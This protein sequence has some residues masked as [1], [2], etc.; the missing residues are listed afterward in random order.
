MTD[1]Q[2]KW[3]EILAIEGL[4]P[5]PSLFRTTNK[6]VGK[7]KCVDK[8]VFVSNLTA[9]RTNDSQDAHVDC[10]RTEAADQYWHDFSERVNTAVGLTELEQSFLYRYCEHGNR[11]RAARET[12]MHRMVAQRLVARF[13]K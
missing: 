8:I 11:S 7:N 10:T 2:T 1:E 4:A 13:S 5:I 9:G 3:E 6:G 12:G